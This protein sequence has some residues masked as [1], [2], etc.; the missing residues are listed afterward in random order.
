MPSNARLIS[1]SHRPAA[2]S[3]VLSASCISL[4]A[5][6]IAIMQMMAVAIVS[7]SKAKPR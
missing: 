7:S 6:H 1:S 4:P 2:F 3:A 5:A